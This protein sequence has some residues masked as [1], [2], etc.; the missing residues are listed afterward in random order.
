M[1]RDKTTPSGGKSKRDSL[2]PDFFQ[3]IGQ[4][5]GK[6]TS[7]LHGPSFYSEIGK[8]GGQRVRQLVNEGKKKEK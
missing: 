4:K 1:A 8:K 3:K 7:R 2:D 6:T 5:G